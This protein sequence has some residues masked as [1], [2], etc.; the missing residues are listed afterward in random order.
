MNKDSTVHVGIGFAT[1]RKNFLKVLK[2][3]IYNWKDSGLTNTDRIALHVFIAYDLQY[4]DTKESDF[5]RISTTLK[6]MV[7]EIVFVDASYIH[8][9]TKEMQQAHVMDE[10]E[11][12]LFFTSGYAAMR[13]AVLYAAVK[14][15]M[16]YL[17]FLD[18]ATRLEITREERLP[19]SYP[20]H[21]APRSGDRIK[22]ADLMGESPSMAGLTHPVPIF[23]KEVL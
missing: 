19:A 10:K 2:T 6:K 9:Q 22:F 3:Y 13:N 15:G 16:D 5:T 12:E 1:G 17:L 23:N 8:D 14:E 21:P 4:N 20:A 11:A 7:D 18:D